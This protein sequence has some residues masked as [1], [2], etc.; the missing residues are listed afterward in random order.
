MNANV[1]KAVQAVRDEL[2]QQ[3][4]DMSPADWKELLEEVLTDVEG[5]LDAVKEENPELGD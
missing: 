5:Y 2:A 4:R 1:K 3:G